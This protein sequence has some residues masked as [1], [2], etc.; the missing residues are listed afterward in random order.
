MELHVLGS[1]TALPHPRRGASG[2]AVVVAG[3]A[4]L[5]ECGPGSTRR[6]PAHGIDFESARAICVTHH[7]VDH[8][9]DLAAVLFGRNVM[10]P[11][12]STPLLLAG[13][14]GHREHL[15]KLRDAYSHR[16]LDD[17]YGVIEERD[18]TDADV[19]Q[20]DDIEVLARVVNHAPG[21]LGFRVEHGDRILAFSGDSG[22]CDALVDLCRGADLALLECSYPA[23]RATTKHLNARTAAEVAVAAEL[24]RVVLTHFYPACDEVDIAAE[25]R[26]AGYTGDL[27]LARDGWVGRV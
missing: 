10:D 8:C 16:G 26:A 25:V 17:V 19:F 15:R 3:R 14:V 1:G 13:P 2:Y 24:E 9:G 21:A 4:I 22:P 20:V 23:S 12:T 18:L 27:V 6:W 5:L 11:P 7:H